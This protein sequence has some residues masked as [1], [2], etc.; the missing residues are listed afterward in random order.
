MLS[1]CLWGSTMFK[2]VG[3]HT[4]RPSKRLSKVS[5]LGIP[6]MI[7]RATIQRLWCRLRTPMALL[8]ALKRSNIT[9]TKMRLTQT[10]TTI[11]ILKR[12][13]SRAQQTVGPNST[14]LTVWSA[15]HRLRQLS[16]WP[17][18]SGSSL[19]SLLRLFTS[20]MWPIV[21]YFTHL[22]ECL[23][24]L[25]KLLKILLVQ[26]L[27]KKCKTLESTCSWIR[28]KVLELRNWNKTWRLPFWSK[29]FKKLA[30]CSLLALERLARQSL[31]RIFPQ[32]VTWILWCPARK[33]TQ[34]LASALSTISS[35]ALKCS[36]KM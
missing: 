9:Q 34:S 15:K 31:P 8:G 14:S 11:A 12:W 3:S 20:V 18:P 25:R 21:L 2:Q 36:K 7:L 26:Q 27:K 4:S 6:T 19:S 29:L 35:P 16:T 23:K 22:S 24:S 5:L 10:L 13:K 28:K 30:T 17:V 33:P 32:V 1:S